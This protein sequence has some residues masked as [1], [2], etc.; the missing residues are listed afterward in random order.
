M[1]D[2]E[3]NKRIKNGCVMIA[4]KIDQSPLMDY[5][6]VVRE[7]WLYLLRKVTHK[8]IKKFNR[9]QAHFKILQIRQDLSWHQGNSTRYY[10]YKQIRCAIQKLVKNQ[11]ITTVKG[12][13]GLVI[14]VIK[15]GYYQTMDN[16]EKPDKKNENRW[17]LVGSRQAV[18]KGK[19]KNTINSCNN[20]N[21]INNNKTR[22]AQESNRCNS[23]GKLS[24]INRQE[25]KTSNKRIADSDESATQ[26]FYRSKSGKKLTGKRLELF[27]QFWNIFD[28]KQG[29][30]AAAD[31]W[32]K[33]PTLTKQ[34]VKRLLNAA[35]VEASGRQKI[36]NKGGSPKWAQGWITERRWEDEIYKKSKLISKYESKKQ[37]KNE[38]KDMLS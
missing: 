28:F 9:G 17:D 35:K 1:V 13:T 26:E 31:S 15:Y 5:P 18:P 8:D 6:P 10:S 33:I 20:N 25:C 11:S 4:R 37:M 21:K 24:Y 3:E 14:T 19:T 30:A 22:G 16:Y 38:I 12:K 29:K 23:E 27:Y 36:I 7:V 2:Q 34:L 32:L